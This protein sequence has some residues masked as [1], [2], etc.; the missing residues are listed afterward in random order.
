MALTS[1]PEARW[2][3]SPPTVSSTHFKLHP[4][5]LSPLLGPGPSEA[6]GCLEEKQWWNQKA[7]VSGVWNE[8]SGLPV[9]IWNQTLAE[10][11][12]GSVFS[13]VP[14]NPHCATPHRCTMLPLTHLHP[15]FQQPP[16]TCTT[17]ICLPVSASA[18]KPQ[19]PEV[20]EL[21]FSSLY[22]SLISR[23][24]VDARQ[25]FTICS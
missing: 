3:A 21:S 12:K 22:L 20:E 14:N 5:A 6:N 4:E 23:R 2:T 10:D 7:V 13:R 1:E 9:P 15:P 11:N 19:V 8:S 18:Q 25:S 24:V 17:L 16:P